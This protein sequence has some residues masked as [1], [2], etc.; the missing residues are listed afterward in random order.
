VNQ[1]SRCLP[2]EFPSGHTIV[3]LHELKVP[4]SSDW[5]RVP[6]AVDYSGLPQSTLYELLSDPNCGIVSFTLQLRKGQKRGVRF[7][8]RQSLDAYLNRRA[9]EAGVDLEVVGAQ[10]EVAA[11]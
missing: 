9:Q 2:S 3:P 8:L 6:R 11:R 10:K 5:L 7:I 4:I 1:K